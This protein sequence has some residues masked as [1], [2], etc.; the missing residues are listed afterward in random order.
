MFL[1]LQFS[2]SS[3]VFRKRKL[4]M[5]YIPILYF[6]VILNNM[7]HT[8]AQNKK[9]CTLLLLCKQEHPQL[10]FYVSANAWYLVL[11]VWSEICEECVY[12]N[13]SCISSTSIAG[14]TLLWQI[15]LKALCERGIQVRNIK[16]HILLF[17]PLHH[18]RDPNIIQYK[19]NIWRHSYHGF[20]GWMA[21]HTLLQTMF[22]GL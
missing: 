17:N 2:H 11:L 5:Q 16:F 3:L 10:M 19:V 8:S 4:C 7:Y 14:L 15:D 20:C 21:H 12:V 22:V 6:V 1:C 9:L 13:P 18:Y